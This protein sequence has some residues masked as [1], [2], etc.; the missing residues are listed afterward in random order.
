MHTHNIARWLLVVVLCVL[1]G[2]G[3]A[4]ASFEEML[5]EADRIRSSDRV[6]FTSI[7]EALEASSSEAEPA[8]REHLQY[9][10]AYPLVLHS[11]HMEQG[12]ERAKTLF[13]QTK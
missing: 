3:G 4:S 12:I 8:Q 7:L 1:P 11:D 5:Q 10:Q 2:L 13:N 6:R 9:L